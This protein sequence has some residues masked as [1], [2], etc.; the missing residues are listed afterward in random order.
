MVLFS[1][2]SLF[3]CG[4]VIVDLLCVGLSSVERLVVL[5]SGKTPTLHD[6]VE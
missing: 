1:I 4:R 6:F 2:T 3:R 5:H